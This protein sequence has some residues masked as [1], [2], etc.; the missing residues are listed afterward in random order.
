MQTHIRCR[1]NVSF[2]NCSLDILLRVRRCDRPSI[3]PPGSLEL[4]MLVA[5]LL[6]AQDS[7]MFVSLLMFLVSGRTYKVL[8]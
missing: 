1:S 4:R 6:N 7:I 5:A 3:R 2:H 8:I